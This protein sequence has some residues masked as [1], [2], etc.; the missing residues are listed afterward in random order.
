MPDTECHQAVTPSV[1]ADSVWAVC[2]SLFSHQDVVAMPA[3]VRIPMMRHVAKRLLSNGTAFT[4]KER[5]DIKAW[6]LEELAEQD[7]S[8][9]PVARELAG[10]AAKAADEGP[11]Q[12]SQ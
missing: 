3:R 4:A 5:E 8:Q 9:Q 7:A 2:I 12:L 6:A 11:E 1:L 10:V